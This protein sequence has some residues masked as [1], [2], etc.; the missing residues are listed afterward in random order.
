VTLQKY[1]SHPS[2]VICFFANPLMKLKLRLQIG[3]RL[4]IAN[5]LDQSL[6]LA[7]QKWGAAIRSYFLHSLLARPQLCCTFYK[8]QKKMCKYAWPKPFSEAKLACFD[9]SSTN[10]NVQG[11][12][13][14]EHRAGCS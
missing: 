13:H 8:P 3:G 7:H 9:F 14:I 1:F 2:L 4:L 10:F 5:H 11:H 12:R 6:R